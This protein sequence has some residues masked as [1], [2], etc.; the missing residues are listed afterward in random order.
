[1]VRSHALYPAELRADVSRVFHP[2]IMHITTAP[3]GFGR[4]VELCEQPG[5]DNTGITGSDL[6]DVRDIYERQRDVERRKVLY[7]RGFTPDP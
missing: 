5:A 3:E 6:Q 2:W 1:M 7:L 4:V